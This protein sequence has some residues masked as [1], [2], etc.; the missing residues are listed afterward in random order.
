VV[1]R[2]QFSIDIYKGRSIISQ[3]ASQQVK[4]GKTRLRLLFVMRLVGGA[5][6]AIKTGSE[7]QDWVLKGIG[8][9]ASL[10]VRWPSINYASVRVD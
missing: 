1:D 2:E 5:N 6:G 10:A 4:N 3:Q 7:G 8:S 9:S